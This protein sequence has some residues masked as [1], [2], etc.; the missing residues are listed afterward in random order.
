VNRSP[1]DPSNPLAASPN[2]R[3]EHSAGVLHVLCG[4]ITLHL[5]RAACEELTTTLAKAVVRLARREVERPALALVPPL[6]A[7]LV[8][9]PF[10]KR[11]N[12]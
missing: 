11:D 10:E 12:Q 2:V 5:S 3:V 9:N 8:P 1:S 7:E 4:P 6:T